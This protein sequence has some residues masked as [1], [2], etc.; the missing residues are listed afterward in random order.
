[1]SDKVELKEKIQ[2]VDMNIRELWDEL[3]EV[4]QKALKGELFILNRY[5][6]NVKGQSSE[7]Q[8]HFVISVNE[9]Y[10]KNWFQLQQHPKL[11]WLL[12]CMCSFDGKKTFYHEWIG[13]KKRE[14]NDNKKVQFLAE[15]NPTMKMAEVEMIAK[16]TPAK[17][18]TRLAKDYGFAD[19][20]IK[21]KL[22]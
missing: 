11:L 21:K 5:I 13:N 6:S 20:D 16:L 2:A 12:L 9:Y 17:E 15:L 7:T 10:N 18:L 22:K 1:M 19:K 8:Q 4:N 3:D 14:G